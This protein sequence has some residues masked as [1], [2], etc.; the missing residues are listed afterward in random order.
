MDL[1]VE[2]DSFDVGGNEIENPDTFVNVE[3]DEDNMDV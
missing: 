3:I 2:F 1:E